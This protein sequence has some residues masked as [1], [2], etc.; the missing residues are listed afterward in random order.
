MRVLGTKV[1]S[2]HTESTPVGGQI[3]DCGPNRQPARE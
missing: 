1:L 2:E 3:V